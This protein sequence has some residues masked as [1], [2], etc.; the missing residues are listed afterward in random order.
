MRLLLSLLYLHSYCEHHDCFRQ[1][2]IL[3]VFQAIIIYNVAKSAPVWV[4][5]T[6]QPF[7]RLIVILFDR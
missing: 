1:R 4:S 2:Q 6:Q 3:T 5:G 7:L